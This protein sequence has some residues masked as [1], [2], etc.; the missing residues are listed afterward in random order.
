MVERLLSINAGWIADPFKHPFLSDEH[1]KAARALIAN[2]KDVHG[3]LGY[4]RKLPLALLQAGEPDAALQEYE[5]YEQM[6][7]ANGYKPKAD[8]VLQLLKEKALCYLRSGEQENC[9]ANHNADSCLMP[10]QGGGVHQLTRGSTKAIE[11]YTE[12]LNRT[13]KPYDLG[14]VWLLNIAYMTL[15]QYPGNVPPQWLIPPE[16]F[17][18]ECAFPR[19][20]DVAG[21]V[22][23]DQMGNAGS[24]VMEDFD[25]DGLLDLL[26]SDWSSRGQ[27]RVFR[28]KGDGTF[29]DRT[30]EAGLLGMT[31]GLNMIQGDYN[32]DG[33]ADIFVLRGAWLGEAGA[34][35]NSLLRNN[36]D[37][38]FT[39]VT[40]ET[41]L[42]S[43]HP[44][45]TAVWFD[46]NGDGWLDL[47]IGNETES[48]EGVQHS[49]E[50]FRNNGD[51]TFKECAAESGV[52]AVGFFK[53]VVTADYNRDGR[54]DLYLS[55]RNSLNIL[56]RNDGPV[57][58]ASGRDAPW[59]FTDVAAASGVTEPKHSFACFFWDYD[60][61]GW[62][63]LMVCGYRIHGVVD[64]AA[65]YLGLNPIAERARLYRNN[66]DGTFS[67]VSTASHLSKVLHAMSAN[68]GDLD[69]DGWL[70][71]YLGT[72]DPDFTTLIP[73]RMFR[74]AGGRFFQDVTTAGG[75]GQLQK[76]HGIAFG[77]LDNDGDQDIYS[78]VGGAYTGDTFHKQLFLNPGFGNHWVKLM[79]TGVR[80][81]RSAIG[82]R[83]RVDVETAEGPRSIFRTVSS[84]ASFG[85]S[86]LRQEI[87]LGQAQR[88]TRVVVTWPTTGKTQE[89]NQV[90]LD[91]CYSIREGA[92]DLTEVMLPNFSLSAIKA[93]TKGHHH[94]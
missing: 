22:G 41:G 56:F 17:A 61:D 67:D 18:S 45:Q 10:I 9:L 26:I 7:A 81:N 42:L 28:N 16:Y 19:F 71:F 13:Q 87:G 52:A 48:T 35:P 46:F 80:S 58:N 93:P 12:Y 47:F 78:V 6:L 91:R 1:V 62:D 33:F 64:V 63:D 31:S 57:G 11:Q 27:I 84:G 70:D 55:S 72:G 14:V 53:A 2:T 25:H 75:F 76:G 39:D 50:L 3:V 79:L 51:G 73:N 4:Q 40:E 65:D 49:C 21:A 38:T 43:F 74:N 8:A 5:R 54:P 88:V 34:V 69:N 24:V 30:A 20:P 85:A 83:I 82:A 66:H 89:F 86:P 94:H 44:T 15:G 77:D 37:F 68:F 23:L 92:A 29:A 59:H 32:N 36:G 90:S 60:N